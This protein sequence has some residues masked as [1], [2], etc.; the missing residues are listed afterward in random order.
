MA[1]NG[2]ISVVKNG[3]TI[4]KCVAGCNG[5]T[6]NQTADAIKRLENPTIDQ[7]YKTCLDYNFGCKDCTVV[8]TEN[9][10]RQ[11]DME[12]DLPELF[13]KKF[14]DPEFNPRWERGT[15]SHVELITK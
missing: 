13:K 3:K 10:F 14:S 6:A 7:V 5:M 8:Q 12:D 11:A 1:T 4:F 9:D 2:I 15:A